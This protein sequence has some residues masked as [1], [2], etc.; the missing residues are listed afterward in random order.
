LALQ[1]PDPSELLSGRL[2]IH[3][4]AGLWLTTAAIWY[5]PLSHRTAGKFQTSNKRHAM[6]KKENARKI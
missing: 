5:P 2:D 3:G 6:E 4:E 1:I